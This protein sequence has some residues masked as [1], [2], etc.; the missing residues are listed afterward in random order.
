M[1]SYIINDHLHILISFQTNMTLFPQW[2][3]KKYVYL[4]WTL[5]FRHPLLCFAEESQR[6]LNWIHSFTFL[7]LIKLNCQW[8]NSEKNEL[9]LTLELHAQKHRMG[10]GWWHWQN[11]KGLSYMSLKHCVFFW[12]WTCVLQKRAWAEWTFDWMSDKS[13]AKVQNK[14]LAQDKSEID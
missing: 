9:H 10:A 5:F 7:C 14:V 6:D 12:T 11:K 2:N 1:C 3:K 13:Y 8:F 4:F